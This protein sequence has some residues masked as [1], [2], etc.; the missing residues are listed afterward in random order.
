M[1]LGLLGRPAEAGTSWRCVDGY[2][3][4]V[5]SM[6]TSPIGVLRYDRLG[7]GLRW[8]T[9]HA[10]RYR[11]DTVGE[12]LHCVYHDDIAEMVAI[13]ELPDSA[14]EVVTVHVCDGTVDLAAWLRAAE[15]GAVATYL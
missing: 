13:L 8:T 2:G 6:S 7:R 11:S 4:M 1:T 14:G 9:R 3:D 5:R 12:A 10:V 15:Q